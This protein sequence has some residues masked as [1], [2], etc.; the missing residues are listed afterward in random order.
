MNNITIIKPE[1][2]CVQDWLCCCCTDFTPPDSNIVLA[3]QMIARCTLYM[4]DTNVTP[5]GISVVF[6][7]NRA[8]ISEQPHERISANRALQCTCERIH[9]ND[10][11]PS[12]EA[13]NF[14]Y[15]SG[16]QWA[17]TFHFYCMVPPVQNTARF[18][19]YM[20][21]RTRDKGL[22]KIKRVVQRR[23][24]FVI[25]NRHL[26]RWRTMLAILSQ[27]FH[28]FV[29][30]SDTKSRV[31]RTGN[32]SSTPSCLQLELGAQSINDLA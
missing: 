18:C 23:D 5:C 13:S 27:W 14:R 11:P 12:P 4:W 3:D 22:H 10:S 17:Y 1:S 9:T 24:S 8:N 32:W 6:L 26:S 29:S 21:F 7:N 16:Q 31:N 15:I 30:L 19:V 25:H 2:F 20:L 28:Q